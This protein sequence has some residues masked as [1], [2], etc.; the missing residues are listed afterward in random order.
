MF[1]ELLEK[2]YIEFL[3]TE[4]EQKLAGNNAYEIRT[5]VTEGK[6]IQKDEETR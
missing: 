3:Q 1:T 5:K 4:W 2:S 6:E